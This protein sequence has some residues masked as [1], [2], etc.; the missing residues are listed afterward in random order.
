TPK[1]AAKRM[2]HPAALRTDRYGIHAGSRLQSA[3]S[4]RG[5]TL[6]LRSLPRLGGLSVSL[7]LVAVLSGGQ[8]HADD[9]GK[10]LHDLNRLDATIEPLLH[11]IS[12]DEQLEV[13]D[14]GFH[15]LTKAA[16]IVLLIAH[17]LKHDA[18]RERSRQVDDLPKNFDLLR[19]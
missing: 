3:A 17:R 4:L 7:L 9:M 10:N 8:V 13:V 12:A 19:F 15:L 14:V 11:A 2:C 1:S 18:R 6:L 16:T 5:S